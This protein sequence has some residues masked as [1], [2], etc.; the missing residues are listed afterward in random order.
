MQKREGVP[1]HAGDPQGRREKQRAHKLE[2]HLSHQL[3]L[4]LAVEHAAAVSRQRYVLFRLLP[5][6]PP[7][8]LQNRLSGSGIVQ[9]DAAGAFMY[10]YPTG[11]ALLLEPCFQQI[12]LT[13]A[14]FL[15]F[16]P[17]LQPHPSAA[18]VYDYCI[19]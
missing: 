8:S 9:D 6:K 17:A 2:C 7:Y 12:C 18:L 10:R 5:G 1:Q 3:F 14:H 16:Q 13:Q 19:H 4:K 11:P 15:L